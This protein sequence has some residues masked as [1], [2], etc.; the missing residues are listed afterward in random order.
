MQ[1][2]TP[3]PHRTLEGLL[4]QLNLDVDTTAVLRAIASDGDELPTQEVPLIHCLLRRLGPGRSGWESPRVQKA[5][6]SLTAWLDGSS[7]TGPA[8][9]PAILREQRPIGLVFA[10]Q[11]A[12]WFDELAE[13]VASSA[14]AAHTVALCVRSLQSTFESLTAAEQAFFPYGVDV[15]GWLRNPESRPPQHALLSAVVAFPMV[16]ALQAAHLSYLLEQGMDRPAFRDLVCV[17]AG[18]SSGLVTAT[19]AAETWRSEDPARRAADYVRFQVFV[20]LRASELPIVAASPVTVARCAEQGLDAPSGMAAVTG[21]DKATLQAAIDAL[22]LPLYAGVQ[23]TRLRH[24]VSGAPDHLDTLRIAL[25]TRFDDMTKAHKLG[26]HFGHLPILGW[27][28]LI[29]KRPFH[30]PLLTASVSQVRADVAD[31]EIIADDLAFP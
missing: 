19:W 18:H 13:L 6:R 16:F 26:K 7:D 30:S 5:R 29:M 22:G 10:G 8:V 15:A 25:G 14:A 21:M 2:K 24:V 31:F 28:Y 17:A 3:D 20:A 4:P 1:N 12:P 11:G 9:G 23:N 27:E